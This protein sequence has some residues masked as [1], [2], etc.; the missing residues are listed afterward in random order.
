MKCLEKDR[1]RRYETAN[2][3]AADLK[4]HLDN[5]PVVAR[6]PSTAY[7]LQKAIRRNKLAFTA[8]AAVAA[9]LVVGIGISS[10]QAMVATRARNNAVQATTK[11]VAAQKEAET[12]RQHSRQLLYAA[13]INLAQQALKLNDLRQARRLLDRHRPQPGEEDLRDWEWRYLWQLTRGSVLVT[14]TNR[15]VGGLSVSFSADGTRLAVGWGDGRVD[16]WDVPTRR[17]IRALTEAGG[18]SAGF[19]AFSPAR[20]LLA[21]TSETKTVT[22]YDLDSGRQS[23]L[24]QAPA[25]GRWGVY[26]LA[27][28]EDGSKVVIYASTG[29]QEVGDA[30]WVVGVS[31]AEIES[32]HPTDLSYAVYFAAARLSPDNQRLYLSRS[33][34]ANYRCSIQCLDLTTGRQLWQSEPQR[35][36]GITALAVSPDGRIL[37]SGS[38]QEDP[39]I[40]VWDA[41]T[42]RLLRQI[43]GH[44]GCLCR[45]IFTKDGHRLISAAADQ[46][47]RSWDTAA[48]TELEVLRG[49]TGSVDGVA[50]SETAQLIASVSSNG[51]LVLWKNET[52][53]VGDGYLRLPES[54]RWNEV[55][56]LDRS[57]VMVGHSKQPPELFDLQRGASLGPLTNAG[58]WSNMFADFDLHT[59]WLCR[60]D[61]TNQIIVEQW[62]GSQFTRRGA[63]TLD[64]RTRP[65]AVAFNPARQLVAWNEPAASNS[66]SLA[67]LATPE[68]R[69]EL[70][71]DLTGLLPNLFSDEGK[72]LAAVGPIERDDFPRFRGTALR[73]W[74]VD[75]GQ[76][77]VALSEPVSDEA[78]AVGGRVLVAFVMV[79]GR[80]NEIRFY[81]LDHPE[82]PPRHIS[83]KSWPRLLAVSPNGRLVAA[84]T[85]ASTV[86]LCDAVTGELLADLHGHTLGCFGV[87]FSK[88]GR[89]L[90][91]SCGGREAVKLWDVDTRQELLNL[92]GTGSLLFGVKWSTD[93]DTILA[94]A[95]WQ[96]WHAPS[97]EEIA[98]TEAK[99]KAEAQRQ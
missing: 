69:T 45:L 14:L 75:T 32:R 68:R 29:A 94:G 3:L 56:P 6:P 65:T 63:V 53:G 93:E 57:R 71:S 58:P 70:H 2:G 40:H 31:S 35:D 21:A 82:W 22:L 20:N 78:F 41:A 9:A 91:S 28:S 27:F 61:G 84:A 52:P 99:E 79:S 85:R 67:A 5:E 34:L 12:E 88:D 96:A 72:Y 1:A 59:N 62:S 37:A 98:A 7:R 26:D 38:G 90:V 33:D 66:V 18:Q 86:R 87:A 13:E 39:T 25:Q 24:W 77:V 17:W 97:W 74:N 89:R 48:W 4:R 19:V 60:W 15:P 95:P 80:D 51:D 81:N 73:V 36:L 8:G 83:G 11:A 54:A 10:W 49:H 47:I 50:I 55:L 46:T 76:S 64:S 30:V 44:T 43:A 23:I 92:P 42:G 16:L